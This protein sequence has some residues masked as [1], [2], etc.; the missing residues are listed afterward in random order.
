MVME[1]EGQE[2]SEAVCWPP[3]S[4]SAS[5]ESLGWGQL[6]SPWSRPA[7]PAPPRAVPLARAHGTRVLYEELQPRSPDSSVWDGPA[8]GLLSWASP[9]SRLAAALLGS[10]SRACLFL[11]PRAQ[12]P[13]SPDDSVFGRPRLL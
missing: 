9:S 4:R 6:L 13:S 5:S 8:F 2:S 12:L 3:A 11:P 1:G 7:A 10:L